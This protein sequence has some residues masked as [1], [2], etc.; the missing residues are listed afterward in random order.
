[1]KDEVEKLRTQL[2]ELQEKQAAEE[3]KAL[4][5]REE[6]ARRLAE[7]EAAARAAAEGEARAKAEHLAEE[8]RQKTLMADEETKR[9]AEEARKWEEESIERERER[10]RADKEKK[11]REEAERERAEREKEEGPRPPTIGM[12]LPSGAPSAAV[13]AAPVATTAGGKDA[14]DPLEDLLPKPALDFSHAPKG[15]DPNDPYNI[16]KP[17]RKRAGLAE[18]VA[19]FVVVLL[20]IGGGDLRGIRIGCH[21]CTIACPRCRRCRKTRRL[22]N[23]LRLRMRR[24]VNGVAA[25]AGMYSPAELRRL[26]LRRMRLGLHRRRLR[27]SL[28]LAAT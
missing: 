19:A 1:M 6:Q 5:E 20:L 26:R 16:Y 22:R 27:A 3:K 11:E 21:F 13:D 24:T 15:L 4:E 8:A 17:L 2:R 10:K 23:R 14:V 18:I 28:E 12:R 9:A 25:N 7:A